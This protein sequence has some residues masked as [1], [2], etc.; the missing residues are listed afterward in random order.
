VDISNLL[1]AFQTYKAKRPRGCSTRDMFCS[2]SVDRTVKVEVYLNGIDYGLN[3][4]DRSDCSE[5]ILLLNV[6]FSEDEA[7]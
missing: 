6:A 7:G 4:H 1:K 2:N 3:R 5:A